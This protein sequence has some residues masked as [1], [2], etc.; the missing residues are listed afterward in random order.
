M[1]YSHHTYLRTTCRQAAPPV[2]R[3][4]ALTEAES[5]IVGTI[6]ANN[7]RVVEPARLCLSREEPE[8]CRDDEQNFKLQNNFVCAH[9]DTVIVAPLLWISAR[10]KPDWSH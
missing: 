10:M 2:R 3:S 6:A 5:H 1:E 9:T 8:P 4:R 7:T